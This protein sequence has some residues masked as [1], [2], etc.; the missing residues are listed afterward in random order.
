MTKLLQHIIIWSMILLLSVFTPGV[1]IFKWVCGCT[2]EFN[3]SLLAN[4]D[5]CKKRL[6]TATFKKKPAC[7]KSQKQTAK[8]SICTEKSCCSKQV[9]T[10]KLDEQSLNRFSL[11][12]K[13]SV[14]QAFILPLVLTFLY[15]TVQ[16][17]APIRSFILPKP[18]LLHLPSGK[19]ICL[20]S[21]KLLN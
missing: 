13:G 8:S 21:H 1:S 16:D 3:V 17:L 20:S 14:M 7:C 10:L 4:S 5:P 18:P 9:Q 15:E 11:E 6:A 2:G 12:V 19:D